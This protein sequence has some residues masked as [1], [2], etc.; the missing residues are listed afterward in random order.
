[1]Q[2]KYF[3]THR[4]ASACDVL[5]R[6]M[7]EADTVAAFK[8]LLDGHMDMQRCRGFPD[9]HGYTVQRVADR[10]MEITYCVLNISPILSENI[11]LPT[12]DQQLNYSPHFSIYSEG[13]TSLV[14]MFQSIHH[15]ST[16]RNI[17]LQTRLEPFIWFPRGVAWDVM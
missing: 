2:G 10:Q 17:I 1:M 12:E 14:T 16:A 6:V 15:Q 7:V 3:V 9:R 8:K 5:L 13:V 11:K 4:V